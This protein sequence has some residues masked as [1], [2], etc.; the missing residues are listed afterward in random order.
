[1][2]EMIEHYNDYFHESGLFDSY[3]MVQEW[4]KQRQAA[5][6]SK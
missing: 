4:K 1:M 2:R 3:T 5:K 6:N